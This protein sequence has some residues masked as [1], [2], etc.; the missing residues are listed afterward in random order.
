[1][2][3]A[4][5]SWYDKISCSLKFDML[6]SNILNIPHTIMATFDKHKEY[7]CRL[8][9]AE[10]HRKFGMVAPRKEPKDDN[11]EGGTG[12]SELNPLGRPHPLLNQAAQFAGEY[13]QET[14]LVPENPDAAKRL[15][16][17]LGARHEKKHQQQLHINPTPMRGG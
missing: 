4:N 1:M 3:T 6:K 7:L 5:L 16:L 14:P 15:Q 11:D 12:G 8:T 2:P 10:G 13:N 17:E 9:L